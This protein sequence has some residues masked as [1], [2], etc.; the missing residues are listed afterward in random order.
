MR[1]QLA[2]ELAW[3]SEMNEA[4]QHII[5]PKSQHYL[6]CRLAVTT[7]MLW[8]AITGPHGSKRLIS[9]VRRIF[10]IDLSFW[11]TGVVDN[12]IQ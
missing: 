9:N 5:G 8:E 4:I 3:V 7:V 12:R 10:A 6:A 2:D 1:D 11:V